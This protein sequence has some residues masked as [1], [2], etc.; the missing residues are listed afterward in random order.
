MIQPTDRP[1]FREDISKSVE[2]LRNGNFVHCNSDCGWLVAC[3]AT[4]ETSASELLKWTGNYPASDVVLLVDSTARIQSYTNELPEIVWDLI[5]V[6][7]KPIIVVLDGLTNLAEQVIKNKHNIGWRVSSWPFTNYLSERFRKPILYLHNNDTS[8]STV[9]LLNENVDYV[10]K[11]NRTTKTKKIVPSI[12]KVGK[13][14]RI[15]II[16]K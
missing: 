6:S 8:T 14:N 10:V 7:E 11:F 4:N 12:I 3:D 2:S 1:D 13:G 9:E 16:R 15:E 5:E